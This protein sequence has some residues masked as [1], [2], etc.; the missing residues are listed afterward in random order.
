VFREAEAR[1][2]H[3]DLSFSG[4]EVEKLPLVRPLHDGRTLNRPGI[5]GWWAMPISLP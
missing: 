3:V 1:Q 5:A 4:A 2:R